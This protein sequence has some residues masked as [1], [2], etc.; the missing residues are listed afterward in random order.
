MRIVQVALEY[1]TSLPH[2]PDGKALEAFLAER[3]KK[4]PLRFPDLSLVIVKLMGSGQYVVEQSHSPQI[5][6]FGLAV[7]DYMHSTAPNR[8]FPDLITFRLIKSVLAGAP[9]PY[10]IT[11]LADLAAHCTTQEDAAQK[12]ER[13]VRKSEAALLLH[14]FMGQQFEGVIT[15]AGDKGTWVR[16]FHPPAEGRLTGIFDRLRVG[17]TVKVRLISTSVERGFIDF[18]LT[19]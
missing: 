9:Q 12:V 17:Q 8:R 10:S 1:G 3:H 18:A 6:H 11:E 7:R 14:G 19:H 15:G 13:Q 16:I 2:E 4:D 5:G